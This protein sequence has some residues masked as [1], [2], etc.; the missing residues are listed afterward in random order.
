MQ[1]PQSP[2]SQPFFTPKQPSSRRN[3]RRHWPGRGV[4]EWLVPLTTKVMRAAPCRR[5]RGG[6]PRRT[7][8]SCAGARPARHAG[9]RNTAPSECSLRCVRAARP[10]TAGLG[11]DKPD[12]PRRRRGDGQGERCRRRATACR[13]AS[14]PERPSGVSADLAGTRCAA[15]SAVSGKSMARSNS[16]GCSALRC[17]ANDEVGDG[18]APLA[19]IRRPDRADAVERRRSARSS[20]P[21]AAPCRDCRRPWP[22]SRS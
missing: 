20:G 18:D 11:N 4:A 16:P 13:S 5:V 7:A 22:C 3:V 1:A 15:R 21:P 10:P 17:G 14:A 2:A 6:F 12:R 9:R 19:A 8:A